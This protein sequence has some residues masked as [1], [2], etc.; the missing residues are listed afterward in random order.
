MHIQIIIGSTR[1]ARATPR[2]ATWVYDVAMQQLP[3]DT[4][5]LVDL[6]DYPLPFFDEPLPPLGN[7]HR[8]LHPDVKR[9]LDTLS[10]ADAYIIVT[11][12][13]NHSYP[14]VLKNALDYVDTQLK[15]KPVL[16]VGHGSVGGERAIKHLIDVLASNIGAKPLADYVTLQGMVMRGDIINVNGHLDQR[17]GAVEQTLLSCL[18]SIKQI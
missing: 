1:Q 8:Q 17:Y 9:W 4:I 11:P 13:Y 10:R 12:E 18:R 2:V 15:D 6:A 14:A 16:L 7:K 3:E 5:E